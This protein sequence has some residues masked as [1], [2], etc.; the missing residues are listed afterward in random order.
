VVSGN[1]DDKGERLRA[2]AREGH[3]TTMK[4]L[5]NGERLRAAAREGDMPTIKSLLNGPHPPSIDAR[6]RATQR[7][8]LMEAAQHAQQGPLRSLIARG[9]D[10]N[11]R[12]SQGCTPL[13]L[14]VRSDPGIPHDKA[15]NT[16]R[17]LVNNKLTI[18]DAQDAEGCTA[19]MHAA[20]SGNKGLVKLLLSHK[21]KRDIM[22]MEGKTACDLTTCPETKAILE[23]GLDGP[24]AH[25]HSTIP[26]SL[27]PVPPNRADGGDCA[28]DGVDACRVRPRSASGARRRPRRGGAAALR[29]R[30]TLAGPS[31]HAAWTTPPLLPWRPRGCWRR[32]W[33]GRGRKC[34]GC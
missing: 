29:R 32:V 31:T 30:R 25:S 23:V 16:V 4:S 15:V 17:A 14:A 2:A 26:V 24:E 10:V 19:L 11:A 13:M 27:T 21:A 20:S 3:I 7:T 5:L 12:D 22:N 6:D 28:D 1:G 33:R 9:A 34:R 18:V 8:P